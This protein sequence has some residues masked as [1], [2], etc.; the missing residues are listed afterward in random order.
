VVLIV[1]RRRHRFERVSHERCLRC[2]ER[3]FDLETSR[4]FDNA[5]L[6]RRGR[7]VA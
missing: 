5:V 4:F 6:G 3:L 2:G 7:H 1:G